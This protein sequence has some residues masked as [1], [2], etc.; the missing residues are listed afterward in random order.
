MPPDV[1]S[2]HTA[3]AARLTPPSISAFIRPSL[4]YFDYVH[5][6]RSFCIW[7]LTAGGSGCVG[8]LDGWRGLPQLHGSNFHSPSK[9]S[10]NPSLPHPNT[11]VSNCSPAGMLIVTAEKAF[12]RR[13]AFQPDPP[14]ALPYHRLVY[15]GGRLA[16]RTGEG[17]EGDALGLAAGA[18]TGESPRS[19]AVQGALVTEAEAAA[20]LGAAEEP[21]S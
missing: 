16:Y 5:K 3:P 10:L 9:S 19:A 1:A 2:A 11:T 12:C 13:P 17:E 14:N 8:W 4:H 18:A 15:E 20:A 21:A 7:G 6:G